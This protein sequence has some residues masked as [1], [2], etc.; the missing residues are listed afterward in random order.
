[1]SSIGYYGGSDNRTR[2]R[3]IAI[4][5]KS[6]ETVPFILRLTYTHKLNHGLLR[7]GYVVVLQAPRVSETKGH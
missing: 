6:I 4:D 7:V 3:N 1:M 2:K 5:G